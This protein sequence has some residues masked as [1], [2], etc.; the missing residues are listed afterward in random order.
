MKVPI[1][2]VREAFQKAYGVET[3]ES[4]E[5]DADFLENGIST[6]IQDQDFLDRMKQIAQTYRNKAHPERS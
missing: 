6:Y 2:K 1:K 4:L 3:P 5:R